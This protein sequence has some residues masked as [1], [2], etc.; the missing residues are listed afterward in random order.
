MNTRQNIDNLTPKDRLI[1]YIDAYAA[2]KTT[3]NLLLQT[4]ATESL[5]SLLDTLEFI[6]KV[7]ELP[8]TEDEPEL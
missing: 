6:Y 3:D 2:A 5:Q 4:L 8:D 7:A 1:H